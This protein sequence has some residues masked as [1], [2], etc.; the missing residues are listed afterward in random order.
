MPTKSAPTY[1]LNS[2]FN[3]TLGLHA[4]RHKNLLHG[5]S[6]KLDCVIQDS[7]EIQIIFG[8]LQKKFLGALLHRIPRIS[9]YY[10]HK[11]YNV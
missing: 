11:I 10:S 6:D 9:K 3:L 1:K 2:N 4:M 7:L 8:W 5:T